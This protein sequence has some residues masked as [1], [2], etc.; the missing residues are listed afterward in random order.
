MGGST[1]RA[2]SKKSTAELEKDIEFLHRQIE[3]CV[4][5]VYVYNLN[6]HKETILLLESVICSTTI[7]Q[8]SLCIMATLRPDKCPRLSV[9]NYA[10]YLI[11]M[12]SH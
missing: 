2:G 11:Y 6:K 10:S 3:V 5:Y 12:C 9:R 1:T 4:H 7:V 8:C